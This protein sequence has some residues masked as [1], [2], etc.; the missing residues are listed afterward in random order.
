MAQESAT[1]LE[2]RLTQAQRELSEAREQ[3]ATT[4]EILRVIASSPTDLQSVYDAIVQSAVRLCGALMCCLFRFDGKLIHLVAQHNL[5]PEELEVF[6]RM[7]PLS[8]SEDKINGHAL[9]KRRAVNVADVLAEY[10]SPIGQRELGYRSVLAVFCEGAAIGTIG[11]SRIEPGLFSDKEVGLLQTFADQAVI[12][13]RNVRLFDEVQA[14]SH[15]LSESLEQQT[16]TSEVLGVISSSPSELE[17]V[18]QAM[19][20][21]AARLCE[22]KFGTLYLHEGD[23]FRVGAMHNAPP[24]F[25]ED[26]RREPVFRP[27]HDSV[28][29]QVALTR[30]VVHIADVRMGQAYVERAPHVVAGVELAGY[31]TVLSVPM[32]KE[33]D[34]IGAISIYRQEVRPFT[35]KQIELVTNFA[36]Q[37]VIAIENARLLSELRESLEQQTATGDVLKVIS[38]SKFELQPVLDALVESAARLCETENAFIFLHESGLYRLAANYGFSEE[39]RSFIEKHPISVGRGT[40]VGRTASEGRVVHIPDVLDYPEYTWQESIRIGSQRTMLALPVPPGPS[41]I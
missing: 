2:C 18:F 21:N 27:H 10:R 3:L 33:G 39:Y 19:L 36:S 26:R 11:V 6:Q 15:E 16:A 5:A 31:R 29:G 17:P 35:D 1:D 41:P 37:A 30:Q 7:Y 23:A 25:A 34:L 20:A 14:R 13:I 22:A 32:L 8:P 28:L 24:A 4:S 9:L 40:L 38:R 12:A